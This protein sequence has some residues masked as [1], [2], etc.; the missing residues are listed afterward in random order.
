MLRYARDKYMVNLN[1]TDHVDIYLVASQPFSMN[2][3]VIIALENDTA[4]C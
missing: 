4:T 3:T 2:T 1:L